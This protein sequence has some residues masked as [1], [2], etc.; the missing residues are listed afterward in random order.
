[1]YQLSY[2]EHLADNPKDS[3]DRERLAL[4]HAVGLL[5][6]AEVAGARSKESVKA[7]GR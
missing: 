1:M 4:E 5:Q 3:R 6:K 2:A 7:L